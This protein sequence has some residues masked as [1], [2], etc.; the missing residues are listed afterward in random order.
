MRVAD[1][2]GP[3]AEGRG[4]SNLALKNE[5]ILFRKEGDDLMDAAP[6]PVLWPSHH[7]PKLSRARRSRVFQRGYASY[8]LGVDRH[9]YAETRQGK[10]FWL[11]SPQRQLA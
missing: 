2:L 10:A 1:G 8:V 3:R 4:H 11:V 5:F 6:S 9:I 7:A